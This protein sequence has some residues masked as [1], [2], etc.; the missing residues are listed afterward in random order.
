MQHVG[1]QT[2]VKRELLLTYGTHVPLDPS[3]RGEVIAV[4][5]T[6]QVSLQTQLA[7]VSTQLLVY[8]SD[9]RIESALRDER[10]LALRAHVALAQVKSVDVVQ[11]FSLRRE[12]LLAVRAH[13][14]SVAHL[15]MAVSHWWDN[16]TVS[17]DISGG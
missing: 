14:R 3:V 16:G 4:V 9:V 6:V 7:S 13:E 5:R 8:V 1:L 17:R 2:V 15:P 11:Q 10:A 12:V